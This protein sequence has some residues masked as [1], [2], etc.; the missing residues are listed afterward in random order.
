MA[1]ENISWT[2]DTAVELY[3]K[4]RMCYI[5]QIYDDIFS[6]K[7]IDH[8]SC[9]VEVGI[10][11]GHATLPFL[12]TGASVAAVEYGANLSSFCEMKFKD[13][14]NFRVQNLRFEDFE[15]AENSV[16]LVYS[17]SAFHW[18]P[19]DIGYTKVFSMLKPGGVFA[20][21]ANHPNPDRDKP[22]MC[23]AIQEVYKAYSPHRQKPYARPVEYTE[24]N[25][26]DRAYIA[27]KYGFTDITYKMYHSTRTFT[28]DEYIGLLGTY[29]DN[30]A[31]EEK[32]R[33]AFF[34]EI[35]QV[36]LDYGNRITVYDTLDLQ[37]A[38]KP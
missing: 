20:R 18:I 37:L 5:N 23:D 10:G 22:G 19:E 30:I 36:I 38:R 15:C 14:P 6:Y 27:E 34:G 26:K 31:M 2:F 24:Q 8:T 32:I 13:Y 3:E 17:A 28:A 4:Y 1:A 12:K 29:S 21:F 25:A 11:T 7:P 35:R 33:N 16:D 9:L